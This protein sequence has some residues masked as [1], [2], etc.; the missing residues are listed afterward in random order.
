M[1][2]SVHRSGRGAENTTLADMPQRYTRRRYLR[3]G[4]RR[5]L[6]GF[7]RFRRQA[8][9]A[10]RKQRTTRGFYGRY[11][12]VPIP[13]LMRTYKVDARRLIARVNDQ[14]IAVGDNTWPRGALLCQGTLISQQEMGLHRI[15]RLSVEVESAILTTWADERRSSTT[16]EVRQF[17]TQATRFGCWTSWLEVV[18]V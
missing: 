18:I 2:L 12:Q 13:L 11:H 6:L 5:K 10:V 3:A 1:N 14:N 17:T 15:S 16:S 9:G 8:R 7:A 4:F